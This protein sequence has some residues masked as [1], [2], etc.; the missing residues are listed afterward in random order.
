MSSWLGNL[1]TGN[2]LRNIFSVNNPPNKVL[3]IRS[4]RY[5]NRNVI[6][7]EDSIVFYGPVSN[8][9]KFEIVIH[10]A[11]CDQAYR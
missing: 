3:E 11:Y 10:R 4:D 2:V 9:S 7:R 6:C 5:S 1:T 8:E